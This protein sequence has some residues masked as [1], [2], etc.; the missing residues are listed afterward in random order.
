VVGA[1]GEQK[2]LTE[3]SYIDTLAWHPSGREIWFVGGDRSKG[4][5]LRA[6]DLA[7]RT[8]IVA[9][10]TDVEVLHDITRDGRALV[11]REIAGQEIFFSSNG[12][13]ERN[14][15]WLESSDLNDLSADGRLLLFTETA[16][17]GGE[18]GSVYIRKTD[19]SP[20]VRLGDGEAHSL[21][22]DGRWAL[23]ILAGPRKRLMLLPTGAGEPK[24]VDVGELSV[25]GAMFL[26][27]DGRRLLAGTVDGKVV[28]AHVLEPGP[29]P[30]LIF[31]G[32]T[33]AG[34]PS[35]DGQS[36]ILKGLDEK[37]AICPVAGGPTRPLTGI[38]PRD[39]ILQWSADG[40][41]LY[42]GDYGQLPLKVFRYRIATAAREV[43]KEFMPADRAGV[44]RINNIA[45]TP[46][47]SAYAY[48]F[49]RVLAS[50]LFVVSG[51]K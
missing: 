4:M 14:L 23:S 24:A 49:G 8:R 38:D 10:L 45:I 6:V 21:S 33:G 46:D 50:D 43:W 26:P 27:P 17:G 32:I 19:G 12:E 30:R 29:P 16:E 28:R 42:L 37:W 5:A 22:P 15:S 2:V 51:W 3:L 9:S 7:G 41:T 40:E 34:P 44:V 36:V 1:G 11:E 35:P 13:P 18:R 25:L 20:A 31:E 48:S 47:G 39:R